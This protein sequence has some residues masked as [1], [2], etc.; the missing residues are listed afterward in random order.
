MK[1]R[2]QAFKM[3]DDLFNFKLN[4][5]YSGDILKFGPKFFYSFCF[6]GAS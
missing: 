6:L 1:I 2:N 3:F 4:L 5:D